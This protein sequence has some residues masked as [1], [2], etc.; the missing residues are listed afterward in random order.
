[1]RELV[2]KG[3][4]V[5]HLAGSHAYGTNIATSDTDYRG[6][7]VAPY[8]YQVSPWH[9]IGEWEDTSEEDTKYYEFT[10]FMTLLIEQNP[11]IVES[12]WVEEKDIVQSSPAYEYLRGRRDEL[13]SSKV[14]FTYSG[15]AMAQL[16]RI[17]G[18]AKWIMN[19]QPEREP[20]Q[21]EFL[22][23]LQDF[24]NEKNFHYTVMSAKKDNEYGV[25]VNYGQNVFGVYF[26]GA[27]P[28]KLYISP[29]QRKCIRPDGSL[30][31]YEFKEGER[32]T[33]QLLRLVKY[34]A[35]EYGRA[36]DTH[37][38]Y[39]T[40]QKN[41]NKARSDLEQKHGFDCKHALHLVRLLKTGKEILT[42]GV[43]RVKRQ[44]F[45]ELLAI[46]NGEWS[47]EKLLNWAAEIDDEIQNTLYPKTQLR[48]EVDK[49]LAAEIL[50]AV[51]EMKW[52]TQ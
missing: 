47:Y 5:K 44:D 33:F 35:E 38:N 15:Y 1:M 22:S 43:V 3:L 17:K 13:L 32:E 50:M 34:N 12:L 10:K 36:K 14:A 26:P 28:G 24:T 41:R 48:K 42:E 20:R 40:W 9:T 52:K 45:K 29:L 4:I 49:N 51:Q 8:K 6:I 18:H 19:P 7:F 11:N 30:A 31:F 46:R 25:F 39:W 16:K 2:E 37:T 23:L 21:I 27:I